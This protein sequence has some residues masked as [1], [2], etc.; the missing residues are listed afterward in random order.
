MEIKSFK[1]NCPAHRDTDKRLLVRVENGIFIYQCALGCRQEKIRQAILDSQ[2]CVV[3]GCDEG[4]FNAPFTC[5]SSTCPREALKRRTLKVVSIRETEPLTQASLSSV[6]A[7]L[8]DF[9]TALWAYVCVKWR[10]F[11][12]DFKKDLIEEEPY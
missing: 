11:V 6:Y 2:I 9:N 12:D 10:E 3:P 4:V 1:T 8:K 7:A 5:P